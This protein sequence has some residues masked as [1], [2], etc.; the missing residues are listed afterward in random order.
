MNYYR[1]IDRIDDTHLQQIPGLT[2]AN[3]H[4]ETIVKIFCPDRVVE[5]VENLMVLDP[6]F[7]RAGSNQRHLHLHKLPCCPATHNTPKTIPA[8]HSTLGFQAR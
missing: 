6:V 2:G 8:S 7:L 4:R 1:A 5:C 3:K